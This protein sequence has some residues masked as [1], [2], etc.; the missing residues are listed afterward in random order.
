M[1]FAALLLTTDHT[2]GTDQKN[3]GNEFT[4]SGFERP[5][6]PAAGSV[7][8]AIREIRGSVLF[9]RMKDSENDRLL[10]DVLADATLEQTRERTLRAGLA[11]LQRRRQRRALLA[12]G[13]ASLTLALAVA[14]FVASRAPS[15]SALNHAAAPTDF[16]AASGHVRFIDDDELLAR[17]ADRGVLLVGEPG[18]QRLIFLDQ[19]N[20]R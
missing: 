17:F 3:D 20:A 19:K 2:N 1:R 15:R 6:L 8:R 10:R 14:S 12:T 5:A 7:I 9:H 16:P 13:A 4:C 18:R 11:R